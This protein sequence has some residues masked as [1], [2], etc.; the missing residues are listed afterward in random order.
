MCMMT[1]QA[2]SVSESLGADAGAPAA[3]GEQPLEPH[4]GRSGRFV[5]SKLSTSSCH[6][7]LPRHPYT[8]SCHVIMPRHPAM[9]SCNVIMP[10]HPAASSATF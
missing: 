6:I 4:G 8:S 5:R 9:S 3:R 2:L 1:W 7:I 10:R